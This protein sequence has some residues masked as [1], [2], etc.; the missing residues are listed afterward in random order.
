MTRNRHPVRRAKTGT[1]RSWQRATWVF[2]EV[3]GS[4]RGGVGWPLQREIQGVRDD[5]APISHLRDECFH[6][7][8]ANFRQFPEECVAPFAPG[9]HFLRQP[10]RKRCDN[11]ICVLRAWHLA[12]SSLTLRSSSSAP[13][14]RRSITWSPIKRTGLPSSACVVPQRSHCRPR[15]AISRA[16]NSR[17]TFASGSRCLVACS[18][19]GRFVGGE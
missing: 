10:P 16:T 2:R 8:S 9:A 12:Q 3:S 7:N 6:G 13:P 18:G 5:L 19:H 11:S 17:H 15:S 14:S 4:R 1:P